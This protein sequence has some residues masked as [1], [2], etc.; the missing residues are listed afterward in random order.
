MPRR[1]KEDQPYTVEDYKRRLLEPEF[2]N[3][4]LREQA[5]SFNVVE[6]TVSR[7]RQGIS[8]DEWD[9]LLQESRKKVARQSL[10]VDATLYKKALEGDSQDR[11]LYYEKLENWSPRLIQENINKNGDLGEKTDTEL[12]AEAL[13]SFTAEELARALEE[14]KAPVVLG[15]VEVAADAEKTGNG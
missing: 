13:K 7:W 15:V 3:L 11:K 9:T 1:K 2:R 10:Y 4:T 8:D 5:G 12:R 6:S 14:K